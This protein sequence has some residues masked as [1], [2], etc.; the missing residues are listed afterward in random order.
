MKNV[1]I[2]KKT[3]HGFE[4]CLVI[5]SD[6]ETAAAVVFNLKTR[7]TETLSLG[8]YKRL[9]KVYQELSQE[10]IDRDAGLKKAAIKAI[11]EYQNKVNEFWNIEI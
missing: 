4:H 10:A 11:N 2:G 1:F 6:I 5:D 7:K 3:G 8:E 9:E